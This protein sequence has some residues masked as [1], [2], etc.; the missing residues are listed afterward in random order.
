M[1]EILPRM[2]MLADIKGM[3]LTQLQAYSRAW[4]LPTQG[5]KIAD[6]RNN[7]SAVRM[8]VQGDTTMVTRAEAWALFDAWGLEG[9][10]STAPQD[11]V[12]TALVGYAAA[13]AMRANALG[14]CRS[15]CN[16]VANNPTTTFTGTGECDI[17]VSVDAPTNVRFV[18]GTGECDIIVSVDSAV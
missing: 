17:T 15:A 13:L 9:D 6:M 14:Y 8:I 7:L 5:M 18:P 12:V 2:P 1:A 16:V 4:E 11:Y 10:Y 3:P